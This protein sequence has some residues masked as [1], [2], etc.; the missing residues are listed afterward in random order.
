MSFNTCYGV[1][2]GVE[3]GLGAGK[4]FGGDVVLSK[5]TTLTLEILLADVVEEICEAGRSAKRLRERL[6][7]LT[8]SFRGSFLGVYLHD[9]GPRRSDSLSQPWMIQ[10][11]ARVC[12][13]GWFTRDRVSFA[14]LQVIE[15]AFD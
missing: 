7:F 10:S 8:F 3:G 6:E 2:A 13:G 1:F 12:N 5:L 11:L 4:Y 9:P 15:N 14:D